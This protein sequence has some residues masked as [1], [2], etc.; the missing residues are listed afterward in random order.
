MASNRPDEVEVEF[1]ITLDGESGALIAKVGAGA[2]LTTV[3]LAWG[4]GP[5]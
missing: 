2:S 4:P 1:G 3:R 5:P